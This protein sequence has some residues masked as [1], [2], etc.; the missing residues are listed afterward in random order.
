MED[1]KF[2]KRFSVFLARLIRLRAKAKCQL[3][4]GER[5]P[6]YLTISHEAVT[7]LNKFAHVGV[8]HS[9]L[10]AHKIYIFVIVIIWNQIKS[11]LIRL[12][13]NYL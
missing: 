13:I 11:P 3:F 6:A 10:S 7:D 12:I 1:L 2:A 9:V 8:F 5:P 4:D